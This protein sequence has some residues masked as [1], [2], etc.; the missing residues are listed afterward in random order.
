MTDRKRYKP[1]ERRESILRTYE[2]LVDQHG[3]HEVSCV[4][5]AAHEGV[6]SS[7]IFHY[8]KNIWHLRR[9]LCLRA[10]KKRKVSIVTVGLAGGYLT[11]RELS[12]DLKKSVAR[13]IAGA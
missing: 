11:N 3:L 6:A 4:Q 8:F 1:K 9:A 13:R 12:D 10:V 5:L 7:L 2:K